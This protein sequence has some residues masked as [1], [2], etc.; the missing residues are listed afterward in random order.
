MPRAA[1]DGIELEYVT[2]GDP[3]DPPLLLINGLGDQ[4]VQWDRELV[5]AF[6]DRGF[7]VIRFD[8]RDTGRSTCY[9]PGTIPYNLDDMME[10]AV[11][12]LDAYD[13]T[14]AA[15]VGASLGGMIAQLMALRHPERV[16][17]LAADPAAWD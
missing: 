6:V 9:E 3:D 7:F 17:Q 5:D 16:R 13:I 11:A 8:N 12:I 4:L 2:D 1:H 14:S 15:I 10:D